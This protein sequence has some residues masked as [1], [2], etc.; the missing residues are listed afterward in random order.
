MLS[1]NGCDFL[2]E[3]GEERKKTEIRLLQLTDMQII[4]AS[5]KRKKERLRKDEVSAWDIKNVDVQCYNHIRSLTAQ[6]KPDLIFISGDLIYG[7]FDDSGKVLQSF[8]NF[9]DSLKIPWTLVFGNHDNESAIGLDK[10]C[11]VY[12]SS[13]YCIFRRGNVSG[14]SNFTIG[15]CCGGELKRVLYMIDSNGCRN[16]IDPRIISRQGIYPDQIEEMCEKSDALRRE[17]GK[18]VPGF[19]IFHIPVDWFE[20]AECEK[21]YCTK[22]ARTYTLG[23]DVV[24]R[25]GDFGFKLDEPECITTDE[26]FITTL[27]TCGIDGV[28][29]G[30]YHNI[31]TCITYES[32]KW[33]Y[34]LKTGQ[35]DHHIP[36]QLGGTLITLDSVGDG[37]KVQH[38]PSLV[39]HG[40]LPKLAPSYR[41][42]FSKEL[43]D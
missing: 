40:M 4:D 37:Y 33:V 25:D 2:L 36:G 22:E 26:N 15:I 23:V 7:E 10:Q 3:L 20:K 5:Q 27:H 34:G 29:V 31:S 11:E 8:V 42:F 18:V 13:E 41:E 12:M 6:T 24:P 19:M 35:Y 28:F 9:M 17:I 1:M 39:P 14:N 21:G 30:H 32:I 43:E 16:T 38:V